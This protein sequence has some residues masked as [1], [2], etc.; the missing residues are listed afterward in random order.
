M[1][2]YVQGCTGLSHLTDF[3]NEATN[4]KNSHI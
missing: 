3:M 4:S 1:G 2:S